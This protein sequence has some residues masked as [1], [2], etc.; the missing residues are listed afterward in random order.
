MKIIFDFKG[1][2]FGQKEKIVLE[3]DETITVI[4]ALKRIADEIKT[5]SNL[6]FKDGNIRN[7]I[8]IIVDQTD[9]KALNLLS[10]PLCDGQ[11]ISVLPLAHGG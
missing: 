7:D 4:A 8:L 11:I 9:V 5:L 3:F 2:I 10:M 1:S 6:L